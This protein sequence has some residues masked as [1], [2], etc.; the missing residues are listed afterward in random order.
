MVILHMHHRRNEGNESSGFRLLEHGLE[1]ELLEPTIEPVSKKCEGDA[2]HNNC[3]PH[4]HEVQDAVCKS[5]VHI[6]L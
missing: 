1:L 6:P 5:A 3:K 2:L 4:M